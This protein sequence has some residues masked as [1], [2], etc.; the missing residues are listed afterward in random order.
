MKY[1]IL[2]L[3]LLFI[4]FS[5]LPSPGL[6]LE[7]VGQGQGAT[8]A[9]AKKAALADLSQSIATEV[10]AVHTGWKTLLDGEYR[11]EAT[12]MI[13]VESRLPLLGVEN[14]AVEGVGNWEATAF[15]RSSTAV[16]LYLNQLQLLRAEIQTGLDH[17]QQKERNSERE[18]LL[19]KL[20]AQHED[21]K[22]HLT[23]L[24][25][26]E[27]SAP[28]DLPVT[29]AEIQDLLRKATS[30]PD[31]LDQAAKLLTADMQEY[32]DVFVFPLRAAKA[33][34]VTPFS[35]AFQGRVMKWIRPIL[36]SEKSEYLLH[37][38]YVPRAGGLE[39]TIHLS[40]S[41]T[42]KIMRSN[43]IFLKEVAY[44]GLRA[45]P[46]QPEFEQQLHSGSWASEEFRVALRTNKTSEELVIQVG[47]TFEIQAKLSKPGYFYIIGHTFSGA[48][49]FSYLLE[50]N[51]H[52]RIPQ[53]F[54]RYVGSDQMGQWIKIGKF[55]A[56]RPLG[57]E[58]LQIFASDQDLSRHLPNWQ[59]DPLNRL[60]RVGKTPNASL[61]E[62]RS[63]RP[64]AGYSAE[65]TLTYTTVEGID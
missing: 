57:F 64:A 8:P 38:A 19:K 3:I 50:I 27:G 21:F 32:K 16:T 17:L 10:K 55:Q 47:E 59:Y 11:E 44:K 37:G 12:E 1:K 40:K 56:V 65:A 9:E 61:R 20:L 2:K 39:I 23:V 54:V 26:M 30:E 5:F 4:C 15:L 46:S 52:H 14:Y 6:S 28:P 58:N 41:S 25:A 31:S 43:S 34:E 29:S 36:D 53:R 60:Y 49:P 18:P 24:L 33:Q 48:E 13:R 22:R 7:L 51:R 35:L 42:H 62:F 45:E 63:L